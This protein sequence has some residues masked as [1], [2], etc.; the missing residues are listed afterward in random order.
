MKK[1]FK[2]LLVLVLF[3]LLLLPIYTNVTVE[4]TFSQGHI[5]P[6]TNRDLIVLDTPILTIIQFSF[7]ELNPYNLIIYFGGFPDENTTVNQI[8]YWFTWKPTGTIS[9]LWFIYK[10]E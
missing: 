4:K 6:L 3:I 9:S 7:T 1:L 5:S 10:G 8:G 2:A